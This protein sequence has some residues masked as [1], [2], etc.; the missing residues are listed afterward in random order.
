MTRAWWP[1]RAATLSS[2]STVVVVA[3]L[4]P[5]RR[6]TADRSS[7]T[8]PPRDL[9]PRLA[10]G[11]SSWPL[12]EPALPPLRVLGA[13]ESLPS[14]KEESGSVVLELDVRGI[15]LRALPTITSRG[16]RELEG[17]GL[18][19]WPA[20]LLFTAPVLAE[21]AAAGAVVVRPGAAPLGPGVNDRP[22]EGL[23][24]GPGDW[25]GPA[26]LPARLSR[27]PTTGDPSS[28]TPP[29]VV[30]T[31][32]M[33]RGMARTVRGDTVGCG[34]G[35]VLLLGVVTLV[36]PP[37][38]TLNFEAAKGLA[39]PVDT[40]GFRCGWPS[41]SEP[42][43]ESLSPTRVLRTEMR[44]AGPGVVAL[45]VEDGVGPAP[46]AVLGLESGAAVGSGARA[47][48]VVPVFSSLKLSSLLSLSSLSWL[49]SLSSLSLLSSP[50]AAASFPLKLPSTTAAA[51]A[52]A[53]CATTMV[54]AG[55]V[56]AA[57]ALSAPTEGAP[58]SS[59]LK[60]NCRVHVDRR[61]G[62]PDPRCNGTPGAPAA[63]APASR[64]AGPGTDAG[65]RSA[66]EVAPASALPQS[67]ARNDAAAASPTGAGDGACAPELASGPVRPLAVDSSDTPAAA[68]PP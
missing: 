29:C 18:T 49:L 26:A 50:S 22:G 5:L 58:R 33:V 32:A 17:R 53:C 35:V 63:A 34:P 65:A 48:H 20:A 31:D 9:P 52:A 44:D 1:L 59:L 41:E 54:E 45:V 60:E 37:R 62:G 6:L 42:S 23:H 43:S 2:T 40:T 11:F 3:K 28:P 64:G 24:P 10:D 55:S 7:A 46:G 68:E 67:A 8:S 19:D 13:S 21:A 39:Q 47:P 57:G 30:V 56:G 15:I 25:P 51:A 12:R 14:E 38:A 16:D 4:R 27:P 36:R 66:A 61:A